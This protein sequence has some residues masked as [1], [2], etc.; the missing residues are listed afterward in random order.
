MTRVL[1]LKQ[2]N[3]YGISPYSLDEDPVRFDDLVRDIEG[4]GLAGADLAHVPETFMARWGTI[5]IRAHPETGRAEV[6][7]SN[8]DSS[9]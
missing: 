6:W 1:I 2:S 9:G 8:L 5:V 3:A 4:A 7:Q